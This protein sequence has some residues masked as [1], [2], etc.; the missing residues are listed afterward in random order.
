MTRSRAQP[1]PRHDLPRHSE[2]R[3]R[4]R[5]HARHGRRAR[6]PRGRNR[7]RRRAGG[8]PPA[9]LDRPRSSDRQRQRDRR[10][11]RAAG[12][13]ARPDRPR[14]G[15]ARR[16]HAGPGRLGRGDRTGA[17]H[18]P[19]HL[20]HLCALNAVRP[21]LPAGRPPGHRRTGPLARL[22]RRRRRTH[23]PAGR[24][25]RPSAPSEPAGRR[26]PHDRRSELPVLHA[27]RRRLP[28]RPAADRAARA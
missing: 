28:V 7:R 6:L 11:R 14:R 9:E 12:A 10:P 18:D 17:R 4:R 8:A 26:A 20:R 23:A 1:P 24:H 27:P 16:T 3:H 2:L 13:V 25:D 21:Q 19:G 22:G 15:P 5:E